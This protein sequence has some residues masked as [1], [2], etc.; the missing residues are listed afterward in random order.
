MK[1]SFLI[2]F[3]TTIKKKPIWFYSQLFSI[4]EPERSQRIVSE[5]RALPCT[6]PDV[7]QAFVTLNSS[8]LHTDSFAEL[9]ELLT[10]ARE[11]DKILQHVK[12]KGA[13]KSL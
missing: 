6:L 12:R 8:D 5:L 13:G 2:T 10:S 11:L 1:V 3:L 9:L 7:I 4:Y